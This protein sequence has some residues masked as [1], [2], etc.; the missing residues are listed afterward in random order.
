MSIIL[1]QVFDMAV[2]DGFR[3]NNPTESKRLTMTDKASRREAL[4]DEEVRSILEHLLELKE[5][6]RMTV[7]ILMM[8]GMRRGE[9]LGIRW[10]DIDWSQKLIHV[11]RAVTFHNNQPIIGPTKSEAGERDIPLDARLMDILEPY[12]KEE[13]Y[14]IGDG[15][16]QLTER[17]FIRMW[18]RIG[19][20]IN[21]YGATPHRMR[22]T[23]ITLA[24]S[25]G[26]DVKTLQ[27][28]AGHA[29]IKMTME[30]YAHARREKVIQAGKIIGSIFAEM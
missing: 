14:I 20:T 13:G 8:T 27:E 17:T 26:V 21:L 1:H 16:K 10:T 23:Y 19:R 25:S 18:Q 29:D 12:R 7:A 30:R 3:R 6:E 22:H 9:M 11:E 24:A 15:Q 28:I 4:K 5:T 2:E